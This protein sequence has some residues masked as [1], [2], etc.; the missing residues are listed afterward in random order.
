M[1]ANSITVVLLNTAFEQIRRWKSCSYDNDARVRCLYTRVLLIDVS[2]VVE[3]NMHIYD[4]LHEHRQMQ[5]KCGC[6]KNSPISM[7]HQY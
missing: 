2:R 6:I 5:M 1:V 7:L 3:G 4:C